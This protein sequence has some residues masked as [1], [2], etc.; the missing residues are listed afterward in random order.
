MKTLEGIKVERE[1]QER[2]EVSNYQAIEENIRIPKWL[3]QEFFFD[4]STAKIM[5]R[6][7]VENV[8]ILSEFGI[9]E[10]SDNIP[11]GHD[12]LLESDM[13]FMLCTE[14]D[15][16]TLYENIIKFEEKKDDI[17]KYKD[18]VGYSGYLSMHIEE[19]DVIKSLEDNLEH[20]KGLKQKVTDWFNKKKAEKEGTNEMHR[21]ANEFEELGEYSFGEDKRIRIT[22]GDIVVESPTEGLVTFLM[23]EDI[24]GWEVSHLD[25]KLKN[26][27][28]NSWDNQAR[29]LKQF[30]KEKDF[31]LIWMNDS[32]SHKIVD[33]KVKVKKK[34]THTWVKYG[35]LHDDI[36]NLKYIQDAFKILEFY[37]EKNKPVGEYFSFI[38]FNES[39]NGNEDRIP[40]TFK[41]V[42]GRE[43]E[44]SITDSINFSVDVHLTSSK[45]ASFK[46]IKERNFTYH[47]GKREV[48]KQLKNRLGD[49]TKA[50][51]YMKTLDALTK[52]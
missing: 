48:Y 28:D 38:K 15:L 18:A 45:A 25:Y 5:C 16:Y 24:T 11:E 8:F 49:K 30:V 21:L 29:I 44:V 52:I 33:D 50:L 26:D 36:M 9:F 46:E 12:F 17:E 10:V 2:W 14:Q 13:D 31:T 42:S 1:Q 47:I 27:S 6:S 43:Y 3:N 32:F 35:E 37:E 40:A 4:K 23:H 20:L 51:E 19:Y 34:K 7:N 41:R 22:K 39:S